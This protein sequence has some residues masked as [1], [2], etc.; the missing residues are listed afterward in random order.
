MVV[1]SIPKVLGFG[2][3]LLVFFLLAGIWYRGWFSRR[4]GAV[5]LIVSTALG[6]LI[7]AP[8]APYQFQLIVLRDVAQLGAPLQTALIGLLFFLGFALLFGRIFCGHICPVGTLQELVS[9][10]PVPKGGKALKREAMA[11]RAVIFVLFVFTG[12]L[13]SV[14][15]LGALGLRK[16]FYL[17]IGSISFAVFGGIVLLS[18]FVYRPFC[19]FVCPYGALLSLASMRPL[20]ALRRT[21]ACIECGNCECACPTDVA[22]RDAPKSECYLCGRCVEACPVDGALIYERGQ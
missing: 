6:F 13:F 15:L 22:G 5:F 14:N 9:L 1:E 7:F 4:R 11:F 12:L 20:F 18:A 10:A 3:A 19:R 8:V 2:Y 17:Q 21:D 16:F